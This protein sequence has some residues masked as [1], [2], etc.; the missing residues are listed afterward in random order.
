MAA[1]E[2][3]GGLRAL[4]LSKRHKEREGELVDPSI[5]LPFSDLCVFAAFA[6]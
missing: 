2:P 5:C 1:E 3:F 4:S 6:F